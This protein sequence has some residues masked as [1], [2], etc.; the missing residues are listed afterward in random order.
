VKAKILELIS[1]KPRHYSRIIQK[2]PD[3]KKW[4]E[5]NTLVQSTCF[6]ELV[7]SA[8]HQQ[9]NKCRN[10]KIKKF[11]NITLGYR[12]CDNRSICTCANEHINSKI[13]AFT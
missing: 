2:D 1:S 8:I 9:T 5:N 3:M 10:G 7:Y 13:L 4:V 6:P 12:F 11:N